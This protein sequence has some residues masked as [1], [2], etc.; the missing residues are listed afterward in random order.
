VYREGAD[1]SYREIRR[2]DVRP[3]DRIIMIGQDG[4]RLWKAEAVTALQYDPDCSPAGGV[5]VDG[6]APRP[7]LLASE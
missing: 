4:D 3:G 5:L 6:D 1:G 2:H 7:N